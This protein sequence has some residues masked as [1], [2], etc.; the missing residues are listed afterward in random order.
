MSI[1]GSN[2]LAGASGQAGYNLNNSLRFRQSANGYLSRTPSSATNRRTWTWSGWV[3][4]GTLGTD[5][6][7]FSAGSGATDSLIYFDSTNQIRFNTNNSSNIVT[8]QVFRDP[9]AWYH[10]VGVLDTTQAT[11]ANRVKLYINGTLTNTATSAPTQNTDGG[12]NNNIRQQDVEY[13]Y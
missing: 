9:S 10:I 5:R 7:L 3:K 12:I 13:Y 4:L 1:I 8:T 6:V 11:A 2:I